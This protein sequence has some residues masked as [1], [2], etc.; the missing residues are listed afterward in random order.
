MQST[1]TLR[2][3]GFSNF[4]GPIRYII[5]YIYTPLFSRFLHPSVRGSQVILRVEL[6]IRRDIISLNIQ[7]YLVS[8][9]K[10][11][12]MAVGIWS[13]VGCIF[14]FVT[15]SNSNPFAYKTYFWWLKSC[16]T[17]GCINPVNNGINYLSTGAGF[18]PSTVV[19]NILIYGHWGL[20]SK[21]P[22]DSFQGQK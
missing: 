1:S 16:T 6:H 7:L 12:S 2:M 9:L 20:N 17:W 3:L 21:T 8:Y 5:I 13:R 22:P 11:C 14:V 4:R 18:Q 10:H 15:N 19:I